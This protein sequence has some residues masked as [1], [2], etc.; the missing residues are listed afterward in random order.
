M[1][2][3]ENHLKKDIK[4]HGIDL[5]KRLVNDKIIRE[6]VEDD[7]EFSRHTSVDLDD[8]DEK[9]MLQKENARK[10]KSKL[11]RGMKKRLR[12]MKKK[13]SN[14]DLQKCYQKYKNYIN[15]RR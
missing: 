3:R 1:V 15:S 13:R 10:S 2:L 8:I 7:D 6:G 12:K 9:I 4:G 14:E 11:K 5:Y